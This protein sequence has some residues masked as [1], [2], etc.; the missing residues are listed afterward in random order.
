MAV[1]KKDYN[2]VVQYHLTK[3]FL[4]NQDGE[5][6]DVAT[7]PD[8]V[9]NKFKN[10]VGLSFA[11]FYSLQY[12]NFLKN[13][14]GNNDVNELFTK[15]TSRVFPEDVL[16][17]TSKDLS[18]L[19]SH[20]KLSRIPVVESKIIYKEEVELKFDTVYN[21]AALTKSPFLSNGSGVGIK[22]LKIDVLSDTGA[23]Y[24]NAVSLSL[25]FSN[26]NIFNEENYQ[27]LLKT[28]TSGKNP[29]EQAIYH[30]EYG[31]AKPS[32]VL[33]NNRNKVLCEHVMSLALSLITYDLVF[34]QDGSV[35]LNLSFLGRADNMIN[36]VDRNCLSVDEH[37]DIYKKEIESKVK[38][39]EAQI[40]QIQE[41][42][43]RNQ[44]DLDEAKERK[45][46]AIKNA[47]QMKVRHDRGKQNDIQWTLPVA[48]LNQTQSPDTKKIDTTI[49]TL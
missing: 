4:E 15:M 18:S 26:A 23:V 28:P 14:T 16:K 6:N 44:K 20:I 45:N 19:V 10:E 41:D 48:D 11:K 32:A 35:I 27:L 46:N 1:S 5:N 31:W 7:I 2:E 42:R 22:N 36:D 29:Q 24:E 3:K 49:G 8:S 12:F 38:S 33:L 43:T 17:A 13:D 30:L 34:S 40:S 21:K 25:I 47:E 37:I 9:C 39:L